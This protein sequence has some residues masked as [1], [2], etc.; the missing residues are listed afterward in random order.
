MAPENS[1]R[2]RRLE[3][4]FLL[5]HG[6]KSREQDA[7][8]RAVVTLSDCPT[9]LTYIYALVGAK[10]PSD[11]HTSLHLAKLYKRVLQDLRGYTD[12]IFLAVEDYQDNNIR[13]QTPAEARAIGDR[14]DHRRL[15]ITVE[16]GSVLF[17]SRRA[18]SG[19]SPPRTR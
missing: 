15:S 6:Q 7:N 16:T 2:A 5:W 4:Q 10:P 13:F 3:D 9:F 19:G 12:M 18:R 17:R 14:V 1:I 8:G 11:D